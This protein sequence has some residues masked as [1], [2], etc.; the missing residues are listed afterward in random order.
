MTP[1]QMAAE[2]VR[3]MAGPGT[4]GV[5]MTVPKGKMPPGFPR[6][7]LLNEAMRAGVVERTYSFK[8]EAVLGWLSKNGLVSVSKLGE[9]K[10]RIEEPNPVSRAPDPARHS[11]SEP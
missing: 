5:T 4:L 2:C 1:L 8:P 11:E 10:Y 6:G 7:E 9:G 3:A